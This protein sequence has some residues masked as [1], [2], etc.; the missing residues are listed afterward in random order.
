MISAG[1]GRPVLFVVDDDAAS[2]ERICG[3]LTR[4][5]GND[6]DILSAQSTSAGL[7]TLARLNDDGTAVALV[8]CNRAET[9]SGG[10]DFFRR[11]R[12][13]HR[14]AKRVLLVEWGAWAD[15]ATADTI[16]RL[17]ALGEIDY[18][19]I[20]PWR[21]PDE[22][23][24]RTI[25][26]FLLEWER[27]VSTEPRE[28]TIV[29]AQWSSRSHELRSLLVRN[30]VPHVFHDSDSPAGRALLTAAGQSPMDKPVVLLHDAGC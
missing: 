7:E 4:R 5:Y 16:L 14:E 11:V 22:Y 25:T 24:H 18:Y 6:Y 10:H 1:S 3:Q 17:M 30:G 8:L 9:S 23:F 20:K 21:L 19:G 27:S 28:V 26:E 12:A 13:L 2:N 15:R 29:G